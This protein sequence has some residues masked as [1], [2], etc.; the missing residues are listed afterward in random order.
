[1]PFMTYKFGIT[2]I[3]VPTAVKRNK[4]VSASKASTIV[5]GL[6]ILLLLTC[7]KLDNKMARFNQNQPFYTYTVLHEAHSLITTYAL[8]TTSVLTTFSSHLDA[9][10][11]GVYT[12]FILTT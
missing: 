5:P 2:M 3:P 4:W 8:T 12:A 10:I 6:L 7:P 9:P 1:M 11:H